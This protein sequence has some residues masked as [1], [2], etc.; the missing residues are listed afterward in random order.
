MKIALINPPSPFLID[1]RV[2][3]NIGLVRVGTQLKQEGHQVDIHDFSGRDIKEMDKIARSYALYGFSS[4]TPQFPQAR[5]L[6]SRLLANNPHARTVIGGPHAS[7]LYELRQKGVVD[8]NIDDLNIFDTVFAGEAEDTTDMFKPG[9]QKGRLIRDIDTT[10][11]PDRSMIDLL[12]YKYKMNGQPTTS[13]QTQRGC[14]YS[15]EFCCGRD[16]EMYNTVRQHSPERVVKELEQLEDEY[17][18][19]SFMWYDDEV[20]I[21]PGRLEELC[22]RLAGKGYQHRGFVRSDQIV[23]HP[24]TVEMLK[25][26]G[27]VKLCTGV[28]SGSDKVLDTINKQTTTDMNYQARKIIGDAGIHYEAF[29]IIGHPGET[30]DDVRQTKE[31][32]E[33]AKPDD[34]DI[35]V[36]TVYP[37]C[38]IYDGANRSDR[39][40]GYDWQYKGLFF[41]KPDYSKEPTFYKGLDGQSSSKTRTE[42]MPEK[43]IHSKRDEIEAMK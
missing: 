22:D 33:K 39:Y 31:W 35:N 2:F 14:P 13:I 34:F 9:W 3:P 43:Y 25:K 18:Y 26:A 29:M 23:Q 28:E 32:L 27:F 6:L 20:N 16:I 10:P 12:S 5:K 21:N 11:I 40:K 42:K 1:E 17:G 37:G 41:N 38:K 19:K 4:T 7:A 24:E 15:C 30:P 36:L 8:H